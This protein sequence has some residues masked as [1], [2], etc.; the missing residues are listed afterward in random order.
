MRTAFPTNR[1][2]NENAE[3]QR[4]AR[5]LWWMGLGICNESFGLVEL[6]VLDSGRMVLSIISTKLFWVL[7]HPV[8]CIS[9]YEAVG[10]QRVEKT[11]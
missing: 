6:R 10:S 4:A 9:V 11:V 3:I 5:R 1:N 7:R 2:G 8:S